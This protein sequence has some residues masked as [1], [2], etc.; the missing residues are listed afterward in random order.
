MS[1]N[2]TTLPDR[3]QV[4]VTVSSG[5]AIVGVDVRVAAKS[6]CSSEYV[7]VIRPRL[8]LVINHNY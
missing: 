7:I 2:K 5:Q 1:H 8:R 3:V 4:K 6:V